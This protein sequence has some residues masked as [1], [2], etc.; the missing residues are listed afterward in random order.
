MNKASRQQ[1]AHADM[2]VYV[3][4]DRNDPQR[5]V[6]FCVHDLRCVVLTLALF[7]ELQMHG[8][9]PILADVSYEDYLC[10]VVHNT[11]TP[12]ISFIKGL[13]FLV[14]PVVGSTNL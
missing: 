8:T 7:A 2:T 14:F 3:R 5:T 6:P 1:R 13:D 10:Y 4:L 11:S 9:L 12:L